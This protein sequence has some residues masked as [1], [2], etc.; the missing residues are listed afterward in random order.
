MSDIKERHFKNILRN[1]F[2]KNIQI[3]L[4]SPLEKLS[5]NCS[6]YL[7][8]NLVLI[9]V[10][11]MVTSYFEHLIKCVKYMVKDRNKYAFSAFMQTGV[12]LQYV[13]QIDG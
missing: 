9:H 6:Q 5:P 12:K 13:R 8:T 11:F 3:Q 1:Y 4:C 7:N 10:D 2:L